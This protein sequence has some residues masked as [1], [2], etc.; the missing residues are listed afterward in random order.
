MLSGEP[1]IDPREVVAL[2]GLAE[3]VARVGVGPQAVDAVLEAVHEQA[4]VGERPVVRV[5][6]ARC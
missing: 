4:L 2:V 5:A 1:Q 3:P 6:E